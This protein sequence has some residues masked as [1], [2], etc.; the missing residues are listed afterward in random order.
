MI[1]IFVLFL[2]P[3]SVHFTAL[4]GV[5]APEA[6]ILRAEYSASISLA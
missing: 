1:R 6:M 2:T 4:E 3:D 5:K